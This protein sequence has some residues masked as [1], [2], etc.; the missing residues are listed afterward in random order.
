MSDRKHKH[1][2]KEKKKERDRH[3]ERKRSRDRQSRSKS[4]EKKKDKAKEKDRD[5]DRHS[6]RSQDKYKER[7][8][9]RSVSRERNRDKTREKRQSRSRSKDRASEYGH[10]S[11]YPSTSNF[12]RHRSPKREYNSSSRSPTPKRQ[13]EEKEITN[14]V[15]FSFLDYKT[16]LSKV[17]TGYMP[18][19][20][21]I[22]DVNDFWLFTK[23]YENTL[24]NSGQ[25]ILPEPLEDSAF[26]GDD[27]PQEYHR[28]YCTRIKLAIPFNK[29]YGRL[30]SYDQ[31]TK[32]SELKVKQ[33]LQIL[34]E[35]LE[36]R[37]RETF[38]KIV[39]LRQMQSELPVASYKA[40]IISAVAKEQVVLVAG[41]TGCGKSTQIPQYLREAGYERICCTQ[42]RRIACISLSKRVAHEMLCEYSN[43]VGYQIRFERSKNK[44]TKIIFMTEGLLLRQ[45]ATEATATQFDVIVLDEVHERHLHG[46][47]LLGI[48][49]CLL[50]ARPELKLVL[51]SATI[52]V[53]LFADYFIEEKVHVIEV[54]GRLFP[55]KLHYRPPVEDYAGR[56]SKAERLSPEPY[57][58]IMQMIDSKYPSKYR[59]HI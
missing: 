14:L 53:K 17:L 48:T 22:E 20:K 8:R 51:M 13:D 41:D 58:Q 37:Q 6:D 25:T 15:N 34:L 35:Y 46:D 9:E 40:E 16:E 29:L 3:R 45:L 23:K 5:R 19:D 49:K 10:S 36:F 26:D 38:L 50:K 21:L 18:K 1:K 27:I 59:N 57:I 4:K 2:S 43:E 32:I 7:H 30:S 39:K 47:F 44:D 55:I 42:P 33:F 12:S 56:Q 28:G 54:P 31:K 24:R 52:N 11:S